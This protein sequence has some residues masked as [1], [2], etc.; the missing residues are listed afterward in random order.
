MVLHIR[1]M[2]E[3]NEGNPSLGGGFVEFCSREGLLGMYPKF[4]NIG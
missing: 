1:R 3:R 4:H 2:L